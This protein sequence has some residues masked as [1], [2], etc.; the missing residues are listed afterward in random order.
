METKC[1]LCSPVGFEEV[2]IHLQNS[3]VYYG[4]IYTA[5]ITL[6]LDLLWI[7]Q[8]WHQQVPLCCKVFT[9]NWQQSWNASIFRRFF[10]LRPWESCLSI[11]I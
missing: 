3:Y 11:L 9:L 6:I 1:W 10:S 8:V 7:F 5:G 4:A 2:K